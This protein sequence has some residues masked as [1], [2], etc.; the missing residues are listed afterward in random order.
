M[1]KSLGIVAIGI[2]VGAAGVEIIHKK[3]CKSLDELHSTTSGLVARA[4]KAFMEGYR[5][6][7]KGAEPARAT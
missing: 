1:Y 7:L 6:A 5:G 3:Y 4:K 2:F